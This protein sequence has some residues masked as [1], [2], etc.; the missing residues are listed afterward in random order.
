MSFKDEVSAAIRAGQK[1]DK[2]NKAKAAQEAEKA[3][4]ERK[5][6]EA[7]YAADCDAWVLKELPKIIKK[8]TAKGRR[9]Y[10]LGWNDGHAAACERAGLTVR[11][12]W[13]A[14]WYD[15]GEK[16]GDDYTYEVCW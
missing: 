12:E 7:R 3:Y 10:D 6:A 8:E 5:L 16:F 2:A 4:K 13:H 9:S 14:A 15:E 1:I 11:K